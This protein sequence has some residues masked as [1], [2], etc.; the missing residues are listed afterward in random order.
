MYPEVLEV[1]KDK[2]HWYDED[3]FKGG[4]FHYINTYLHKNYNFRMHSHQ[5]Y[6]MNIIVSGGGRHYVDESYVEAKPGD[7]FVIPPNVS[8]GYYAN[9]RIDVYHILIKSDFIKRYKQELSGTRE[10]G[11]LFDVE[12]SVRWASSKKCNLTLTYDELNSIKLQLSSIVTAEKE[13]NYIYQN[14]MTLAFICGLCNIMQKRINKNS[15]HTA[16]FSQIV[17][18]T[19]YIKNNLDK[20]L[21]LENIALVSNA[22]KATLNRLFS[23]NSIPLEE[24]DNLPVL[25]D[26]KGVIW[27]YG[28][29]VSGRCAVTE[30]TKRILIIEAEKK[31]DV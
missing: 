15:G 25:A 26:E 21:S 9:D 20:D 3:C 31:K 27:V 7:V 23:E 19:E 11:I 30:N 18:I 10:F 12:P 28:F 14:A 13:K 2:H 17:N 8:H 6:E 29:G 16:G 22:S 4:K 1:Q 5:F 24:R